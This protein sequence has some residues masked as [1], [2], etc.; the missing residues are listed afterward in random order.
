MRPNG[1]RV[2]ALSLAVSLSLSTAVP[3]QDFSLDDC[4]N[5]PLGGTTPVAGLC[6]AEAPYGFGP[7]LAPSPSLGV[8]GL[9]DS[10][11][12]LPGPAIDLPTLPIEYL[13]ALSG[14][15]QNYSQNLWPIIRLRFSVDRVTRGIGGSA[16]LAQFINNQQAADTFDST[17]TFRHPCFFVGALGAGPYAGVLPTAGFGGSNLL[18]RNQTFYGLSAGGY[19]IP[20]AVVAPGIVQ[21]SHD[22]IDAYN[23]LPA[24]T[25]AGLD[26][27]YST[28][29][30][31]LAVTGLLP[32][33]IWG[34]P[35]AG[36]PPG[37]L[38]A[39]A[40]QLGLDIFGGPKSDDIDGLV[41]WD[42]YEILPHHAQPK[43]DCAIF[44]LS[45]GSATLAALQGLGLPVDPA[46]IF[47]TDFSGA[48]AIYAFGN[49]LGLP[50]IAPGMS[51][52]NVDGL[53]IRP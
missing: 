5:A 32:A 35:A 8:F 30:A 2:F 9:I 20:A 3:A 21:G 44:S 40:P 50:F 23:E 43:R 49:D 12:L 22:N 42:F 47:M 25:L 28:Y 19:G 7:F 16:T 38:Y 29:P 1:I 10:D 4:P 11:L 46:T 48:F 36:L 27:Y 24:P 31:E 17:L 13:N 14:N 26:Y 45:P 37:V 6:G 18:F 52:S 33:D 34:V 51:R 41:V 53:E 15:H 39:P